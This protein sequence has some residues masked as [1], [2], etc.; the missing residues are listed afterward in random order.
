M[1]QETLIENV[2]SLVQDATFS[3]ENILSFLNEGQQK[4]AG[5]ILVVYPDGTQVLSSPIPDLAASGTV[6]TSTPAYVDMPSDYSRNLYFC[7]SSDHG[8]RV[9]VLSSLAELMDYYPALD[10]AGPVRFVAVSASSLYYQGI[11]SSSETLNLY[12]YREPYDMSK[13][14][15]GTISFS[16]SVIADSSGGLSVFYSGQTIDITGSSENNGDYVITEVAS[17]GST[18]TVSGT[19]TTEGAGSSVVI[20]SRPDGIPTYFQENLLVN[21]AAMKIFERKAIQDGEMLDDR[22]RCRNF[23]NQAMLNLEASIEQE[24]ESVEFKVSLVDY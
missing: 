17:D 3:S 20:Q 19:F 12:Y 1:K 6:S 4:I 10:R 23:F 24:P 22:D 16:G 15:A 5:G 21:Y 18:I 11:P 7:S 2:K 8:L 9:K 14:T 13:Y